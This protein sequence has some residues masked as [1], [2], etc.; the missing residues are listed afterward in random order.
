MACGV[1]ALGNGNINGRKGLAN[2]MCQ[3]GNGSGFSSVM[4]SNNS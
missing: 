2:P 4:A 3:N 1:I